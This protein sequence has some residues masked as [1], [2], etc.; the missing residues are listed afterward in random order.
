[1]TDDISDRVFADRALRR[2]P[3]ATPPPGLEAA[4]LAAY[5]AWNAERPGGR[6]AAWKG[7][8]RGLSETVWPGAP[9]WAPVSALAVAL[10]V[11]AGL[12]AALP[13]MADA[14]PA[15]F[16]LEQPASFNLLASDTTQEDF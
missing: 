12:G 7:A 3:A 11:G 1:M 6:W 4:L 13:T 9:L 14:E 2:L 15:G 16:S 5:D 10:L 8:L